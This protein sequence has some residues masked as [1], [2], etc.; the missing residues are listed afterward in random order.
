MI[1][2]TINEQTG[3][4]LMEHQHGAELFKLLEVNRQH[5]RRWHP[6]VDILRSESDVEKAIIAWRQLQADKRG[7]FAGI[8]F[9]GQFCGMINHQ[10]LDWSNGWSA[11][12][13]WLDAAHQGQG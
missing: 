13:Y 5:L 2:S 11:M 9:K 6:W 3:L 8:W 7:V 12:S 10:N 4:R 1:C